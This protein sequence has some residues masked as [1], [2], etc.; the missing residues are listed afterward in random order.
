MSVGRRVL[1]VDC[2]LRR[3]RVHQ[4]L[5]LRTEAGLAE[6]LE[7]AASLDDAIL[8]VEGTELDVLPVRMLPP[9]PSEL[10]ASQSMQ[11]LMEAKASM[12]G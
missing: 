5:G 2:D 8:R 1:L 4:S 3:P 11:R 9:N 12:A 10:L 6:V 7:G